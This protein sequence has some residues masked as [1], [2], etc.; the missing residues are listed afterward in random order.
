MLIDRYVKIVN[1]N[2][3][4]MPIEEIIKSIG[5]VSVTVVYV[6]KRN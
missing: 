5:V 2:P 3:G 6:K 1:P 4:H